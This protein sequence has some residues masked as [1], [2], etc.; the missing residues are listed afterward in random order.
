MKVFSWRA[1]GGR[2]AVLPIL[3]WVLV[4]VGLARW[5][6]VA[7][8]Q[9][10]SSPKGVIRTE[11]N[12][13]NILFTTSDKQG[14]YLN[15]L[16]RNDFEVFEDGVKQEIQLFGNYSTEDAQSLTIA[17]LVDTSGSERL[18]MGIIKETAIDFIEKIM[19]PRKDIVC[20]IQFDSEVNL[21]QDFTS[22]PKELARAVE[23]LKAGNSTALYDALYLAVEEKLRGEAG[24]KVVVILSD[25]EDTS[26]KI[27]R[28]EATLAAQKA[29]VTVYAIGIRDPQFRSD[30][31]ILESFTKD[32]GGRFIKEN[33]RLETLKRAFQLIG[34]DIKNQYGLAYLSTNQKHDGTFRRVEIRPRLRGAK[35]THRRGYYAP[36]K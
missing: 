18:R 9:V 21:V 22:N 2:L 33:A 28:A 4:L 31:G 13:V 29:D 19:R 14:R 1:A 20:L 24:R 3:V 10:G 26:S 5:P 6:T 7:P 34:E 12:L 25:G 35:V 16:A 27:K 17:L 8:A 30:F 23:T 11:V 36:A 32:T 15:N